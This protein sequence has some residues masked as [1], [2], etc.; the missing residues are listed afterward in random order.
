MPTGNSAVRIT[1]GSTTFEGGI[2]SGRIPTIASQSNPQ[3]LARNELS[4]ATN[5]TMRGGGVFPRAGWKR[6]TKIK[7]APGLFQGGQIYEPDFAFPYLMVDISGRTYQIRVDTD[8]SVHD[9]TAASGP[10]PANIDQHWIKQGE[11]FLITQDGV[12][13]PLVWD[14]NVLRRISAMGGVAPYLPIGQPMDY[15]M[16][17]QWVAFGR[18]YMAGDIVFGPS[19]TP[20]YQFRDA[21]LHS[22]ENTYLAGGG[23]FIVPTVAGNIRSLNHTANLDTQ[24]GQGQLFVGTRRAIY[25]LNVPP[26]RLEWA[27]LK[28]PLQRVAQITFGMT[29]DR[30]VVPVNGDLFYQSIDGIRSLLIAIRNFS[31]WGNTPISRELNRVLQFNNRALSRFGTGINFNNRMIQSVLP[32]QTPSGVIHQGIVALDFDLI[33][34][35]GSNLSPVWEGMSE[36]LQILQMWVADFGGLERAFAAIV[37]QNPLTLGDIEL[38]ELTQQDQ[39]DE[40]DRRIQWYIETPAYTWGT[41]FSLKK[42]DTAEIWIDRLVGKVEFQ[43]QFRVDQDPCW[44]DWYSWEECSARTSCELATDP[45]CYPEDTYCPG[46]RATMTLPNPPVHAGH[47]NNRP[48]NIGYQFQ[49]RM[50]IKGYCRIRGILVHALPRDKRP[51]EGIVTEVVVP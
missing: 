14:G 35:L 42:L 19:G 22:S 10:N 46:Y 13:E 48:I 47:G 41:Q 5:A 34:N 37:S 21:I 8:N 12:S 6:L 50:F 27:A 44:Y 49:I 25:S 1:D 32:K 39:F 7:S 51:F 23:N 31:Q 9:V 18:E 29:S 45:V 40:D 2:D 43:V 38:W 20:A 3:G 15:F 36:G 30:S 24:L 28:E 26:T 16:G 17:R 4:W 11:Q 33:S